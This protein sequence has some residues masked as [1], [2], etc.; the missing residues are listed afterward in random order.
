MKD[1]D[2]PH[3]IFSVI[4]GKVKVIF[5]NNNRFKYEG[6]TSGVI[7]KS[8]IGRIWNKAFYNWDGKTF[9]VFQVPR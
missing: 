1:F 7:E 5:S 8:L 2:W 6:F 9:S 3:W 4:M